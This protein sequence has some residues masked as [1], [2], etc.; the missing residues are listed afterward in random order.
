[1]QKACIQHVRG[2]VVIRTIKRA[3]DNLQKKELGSKWLK[4]SISQ[5]RNCTVIIP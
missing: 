1:M 3:H 5:N 2:C 4:Y